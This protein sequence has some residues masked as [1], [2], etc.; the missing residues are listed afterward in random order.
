[1]GKRAFTEAQ[2]QQIKD[3]LYAGES[4]KALAAEFNVS[5]TTIKN[6]RRNIYVANPQKTGPKA[7]PLEE[8]LWELIDQRGPDECWIW[9]GASRNETDV[10]TIA[11][12]PGEQ[13]RTAYRVVYELTHNITLES[14]TL[15]LHT[16][17]HPRCMNPS[18]LYLGTKDDWAAQLRTA[19]LNSDELEIRR[20]KAAERTRE[21]Y[22]A[23]PDKRKDYSID[24]QL[25]R[26]LLA[27]LYKGGQCQHCDESHPAALQMHH[28]DPA[29]KS[30]PIN[31]KTL[32]SP[33]R[34]TWKVICDE[35]DKCELLCANCHAKHH[36][37][38]PE[39]LVAQKTEKMQNDGLE[40]T[41]NKKWR[42]G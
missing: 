24:N 30:F 39:D 3:R 33:Y 26:K 28:R 15:V 13:S 10:P 18:H 1:M 12:N 29:T 27:V 9:K 31:A 8:R 7:R 23:N 19:E 36:S 14:Q 2:C 25:E 34:F 37:R 5:T 21:I 16:C 17:R 20:L 4:T 41:I 42:N 40:A 38:W 11:V 22:R 6:V 32:S 35:L